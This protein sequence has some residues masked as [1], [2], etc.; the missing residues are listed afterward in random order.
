MFKECPLQAQV[1][2]SVKAPSI[3][4]GKARQ[5]RQ[6]PTEA[7]QCLPQCEEDAA[8][9]EFHCNLAT[10]VKAPVTGG[11]LAH[12]DLFITIPLGVRSPY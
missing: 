7:K 2:T 11:P 3:Y 6:G 8:R 5:G 9:E 1:V 4:I 10:G 12:L